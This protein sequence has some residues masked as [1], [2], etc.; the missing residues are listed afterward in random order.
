MIRGCAARAAALEHF[1][2]EGADGQDI[3]ILDNAFALFGGLP[4]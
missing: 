3:P 2:V 4:A 1:V